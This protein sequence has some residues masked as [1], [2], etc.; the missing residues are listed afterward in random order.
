MLATLAVASVAGLMV[1]SEVRRGIAQ[2]TA[3]DIQYSL[4]R[5]AK[6]SELEVLVSNA[7]ARVRSYVLS[8]DLEQKAQFQ[9]VVAQAP[10]MLDQLVHLSMAEGSRGPSEYREIS[11]LV[12]VRFGQ[13]F[14][15]NDLYEQRGRDAALELLATGLNDRTTNQLALVIFE[16]HGRERANVSQRS[17]E[18]QAEHR[19][20]QWLLVCIAATLVGLL[21]LVARAGVQ[22]S[23]QQAAHKRAL[24]DAVEERT[25][26]LAALTSHLQATVEK[27]RASLARELHDELGGLLVA[28]RMDLQQLKSV[29][30]A[31]DAASAARF[32]RIDKALD[33]GVQ[34]KRRV[35]EGLRPT[36]LDNL[37]LF[38]ALRWQM[39]QACASAGL[40][41]D[42]SLPQAEPALADDVRI[43]LFRIVQEC[44]NNILKHAQAKNAWLEAAVDDEKLQI[45]IADD[46]VGMAAD[47]VSLATHHGLSGMR[48]R[49]RGMGGAVQFSVRDGGGSVVTVTVPRR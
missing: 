43:N 5:L 21:A 33:D 42:I 1:V 26:E 23:R 37:G 15:L 3:L 13:L 46:G 22:Q 36:L 20:T 27:E 11:S 31:D 9:E 38:V 7:D 25:R 49:A 4:D 28:A 12:G 40:S 16:V 41:H 30:P 39:E 45:T 32:A 29:L 44:I 47:A 8:G 24:E 18:W 34:F 2:R 6:L 17:Q 10:S 48:H 19:Q 35:I 14:S